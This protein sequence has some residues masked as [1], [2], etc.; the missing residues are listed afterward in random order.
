MPIAFCIN[1]QQLQA[2]SIEVAAEERWGPSNIAKM[3]I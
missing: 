2:A 1:G 3:F